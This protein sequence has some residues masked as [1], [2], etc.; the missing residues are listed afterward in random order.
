MFVAALSLAFGVLAWAQMP[1]VCGFML[2][3]TLAGAGNYVYSIWLG[4]LI[5]AIGLGSALPGLLRRSRHPLL[6]A[7]AAAS[8][9]FIAWALLAH[10]QYGEACH[11]IFSTFTP[12]WSTPKS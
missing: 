11:E 4:V 6:L 8:V 5:A 2:S 1:A 7:G 10:E 3:S 12:V 9:A